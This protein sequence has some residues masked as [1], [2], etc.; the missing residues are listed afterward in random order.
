MR[1]QW[2][3][4]AF[5][6]MMAWPTRAHA[7]NLAKEIKK[8][9]ERS[10]LDQRGTGSFHLKAELAPSLE[11]DT[12][13][14]RTGEVEIWWASPTQWRRE[15]RSP[16][17]HQIEIVDGDRVWQK[18]EGDYF[19]EWLERTAI[20]LIKPVPPLN[21]VL[22][23]VKNAEVRQIGQMTHVSWTTTSGT[24]EVP[25]ILRSSIALQK[26]TGLLLYA[27]GF[28][29]GGEFKDYTS[30]H[31]RM[32]ARTVNVGS[33]Q[34]TAKVAVLEDLGQT[35]AGFFDATAPGGDL[36]PLQTVLMDETTLRKNLL[37]MGPISWPPAQDGPLDGNVTAEI[38]IDREGKVR[39]VET[40]ISENPAVN[41]VGKHA[42]AAMRFK[43]FLVNGDP[44]QVLAQITT[45]FKTVRPVANQ[46][47]NSAR[48]YFERGRL[49]GF[50]AAG[51]GTGYVLHAEFEAR[52]HDGSL[53]KGRYEDTWLSDNQWRREAWF[54]QSHYV[55][56]RDRDKR[57]Q[58]EEG[59]QDVPLLRFVLRVLEPIPAI[60]TFVES[61][62][63]IKQDP[64]NGAQAVR[65]LAGS[66]TPKGDP[67]PER[68]RAYWFDPDGLLVKTDFN[69][70]E[71]LRLDFEDFAGLKVARQV[72]VL[73]DGK[74]GMQIRVTEITPAGS[75][76]GKIFKVKGHEWVRAFTDEMR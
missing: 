42:V 10:T 22:E 49:V 31:E 50:P 5:T 56:S 14:G 24:V 76:S 40:V 62:W 61:D 70:I 57:Y 18:N 71:T 25:N 63:K 67:D 51:T 48:A 45:P 8:A 55:R 20:E 1:W 54:E 27:G 36:Q 35:P 44:V 74:L 9:V 52:G 37:P 21:D 66:E 34:V 41:D 15:V 7:D 46:A 4:I 3:I 12:E 33:P 75:V 17:F 30:F 72:N 64:V 69:G 65:I 38:V 26:S 58:L 2:W 19:P 32:I 53:Q 73:K 11:R 6:A 68:A 43:P 28:G 60:D 47:F 16:E 29:W 23:Q 59:Q 13:S 39:E